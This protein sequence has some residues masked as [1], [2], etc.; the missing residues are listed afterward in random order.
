MAN[1]KQNF[2]PYR[3]E[4]ETANKHMTR[5]PTSLAIKEKFKP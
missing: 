1:K 3:E 5:H 4:R 2:E